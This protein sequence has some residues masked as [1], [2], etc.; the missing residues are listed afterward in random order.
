M[1]GR[2]S[3]PS[4]RNEGETCVGSFG[5]SWQDQSLN[6]LQK[7]ELIQGLVSPQASERHVVK[8]KQKLERGRH[9]IQDAIRC[10]G[11]ARHELVDMQKQMFA[12]ATEESKPA[13]RADLFQSLLTKR[14]MKP[15]ALLQ[16]SEEDPESQ[17]KSQ[18]QEAKVESRKRSKAAGRR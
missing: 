17:A 2:W 12:L 11:Q 1:P 13:P 4:P 16:E 18:A 10:C 8:E 3:S 7:R 5:R 6:T 15:E 14:A 9:R